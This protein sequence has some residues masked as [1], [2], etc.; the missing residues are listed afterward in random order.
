ML[1]ILVAATAAA[2]GA[3][4]AAQPGAGQS[5]VK[6]ASIA[7]AVQQEIEAGLFPGA[8]VL[9]GRPGKVLYKE[10]FGYAQIVPDKVKMQTDHLF[11]LAS[12]TKVVATGTAFG[13]CVDQGRL[14]LDT[15]IAQ[16]L[17]RLSGH[18]IESITVTHLATHTSGFDNAKY[19]QRAQGEA[20]LEL[21]LGASPQWK[22]GSRYYYSCLNM[23]LLG[24]IVERASGQG[25]DAF[26]QARIFGPLG[27][28]NTTFG[29]L[30]SSPRVVPSGAR[31]IGQIEDEQARVAGRPVGNAGLFSTAGDLARF[32]DMMLGEGRLGD[33]RIL[34]QETH[35]HMTRN[36]LAPRL[37]PRGL[38]WDMDLHAL[39]RPKRL[40]DKAYGH[41]GHTGQSLWIDPE[42]RVYLIVLTNRNHPKWGDGAKKTQQYRARARIGDAA[43]RLLG[44]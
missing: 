36:Q 42:K 43:L 7:Q 2:A 29:P 14:R 11:D 34:S 37:P 8:V 17:P 16:A 15:P 9:V 1:A 22:P 6:T 33:V 23:I 31:Q 4:P 40:S 19:W 21:M 30:R 13:I 24:R 10:A 25:L 3:E 41:S 26:C 32:C 5:P 38:A 35:R 28:R 39:H 44:Y 20:M 12:V 18:G 27:M